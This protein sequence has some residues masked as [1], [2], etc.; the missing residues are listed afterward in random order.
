M[1]YL[2]SLTRDR[3][4]TKAAVDHTSMLFPTCFLPWCAGGR[5]PGTPLSAAGRQQATPKQRG[6]LGGI[7]GDNAQLRASYAGTPTGRRSGTPASTPRATPSRAARATT[8]KL[9]QPKRE[10]VPRTGPVAAAAPAAS[11]STASVSAASVSVGPSRPSAADFFGAT[12][13]SETDLTNDLLV[14]ID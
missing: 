14:M 4:V 3:P 1:G 11:V 8:P 10:S 2:E 12:P 9:V 6:T 13:A 7:F 5:T